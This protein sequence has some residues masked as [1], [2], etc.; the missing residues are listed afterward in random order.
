VIGHDHRGVIMF[1]N[2]KRLDVCPTGTWGITRSGV[3]LAG[4]L[5]SLMVPE[6]TSKQGVLQ[7]RGLSPA[8]G[9]GIRPR[10]GRSP[11]KTFLSCFC[12]VSGRCA[13][14]AG[15][16]LAVVLFIPLLLPLGLQAQGLPKAYQTKYASIS[17]IEEKDLHT[18]TRNTASGFGF[19]RESPERN[20]LL[21]RTQV[22]KIV[23]TISSL[24]DMHPLN[25]RFGI[26]LYRTQEEVSTAYYRASAGANAY[27]GQRMASAAPIAFYFHRTRNIAVA[28][29]NITDGILAH[30]IAHAVI[31]AYFVVPPP[32]RMQEILAQY[33][34]KHLRD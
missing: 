20:P 21:I 3:H 34:D 1:G 18:F 5:G 6:V 22:D 11:W 8:P 28:I 32:A 30:E 16:L 19:L 13:G 27:N 31:S 2:R 15:A 12:G 26:T 25:L 7:T 29:D 33:I 14:A 24:L 10:K 4:A 9:M 17:Y 23:E